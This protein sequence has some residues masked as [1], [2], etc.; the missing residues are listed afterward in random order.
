[1]LAAIDPDNPDILKW[2]NRQ[3]VFTIIRLRCLSQGWLQTGRWPEADQA[4]MMAY[5]KNLSDLGELQALELSIMQEYEASPENFT[6]NPA[7][8]DKLRDLDDEAITNLL[9]G[10]SASDLWLTMQAEAGNSRK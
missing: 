1:M 9:N 5:V 4:T 2:Q 7:E 8:C 6:V 3:Q 10:Q